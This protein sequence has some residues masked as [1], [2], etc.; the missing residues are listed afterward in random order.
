MNSASVEIKFSEEC[1]PTQLPEKYL[2]FVAGNPKIELV[3]GRIH[4]YRNINERPNQLRRDALLSQRS[5]LLCVIAVPAYM[6]AD[7][8]IRFTGF[9]SAN[10]WAMRFLRDSAPNKYTVLLQFDSQVFVLL[11][12]FCSKLFSGLS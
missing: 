10:L 11:F 5:H 2:E 6:S 4:L 9:Y 7:E 3:H 1:S 12:N 8:F